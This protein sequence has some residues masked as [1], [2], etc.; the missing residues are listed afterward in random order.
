MKADPYKDFA[1]HYD[2]MKL[3]NPARDQFFKV[4]FEKHNVNNVLDC[5]CGTGHE[6][7][8]FSS[9]GFEVQ[10]SDI[11]DSMLEQAKNICVTMHKIG[12][13]TIASQASSAALNEVLGLGYDHHLRYPERIGKVTA[14][15][16]L[17]EQ[18]G[19]RGQPC[20]TSPG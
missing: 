8:L 20:S 11:S 16:V 17:Q 3:D 10:G 18:S 2:W 13:E 4:L 19:G 12:L 9:F 7:I 14:G 15:D 5:A 6:L 1:E